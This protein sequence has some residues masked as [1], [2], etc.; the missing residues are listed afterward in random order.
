VKKIG[1]WLLLA[2]IL[3]MGVPWAEA[4]EKLDKERASQLIATHLKLPKFA[5]SAGIQAPSGANARFFAACKE[6]IQNLVKGGLLAPFD[7]SNYA[8]PTEQGISLG[9][10]GIWYAASQGQ[11]LVRLFKCKAVGVNVLELTV[12]ERFGRADARYQLAYESIDLPDEHLTACSTGM[13]SPIPDD[14]PRLIRFKYTDQ[15]GWRVY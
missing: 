10:E 7:E 6:E 14:R 2:G 5:C 3:A 15:S 12:E 13:E 4:A 11:Y 1:C 9:L 8:A